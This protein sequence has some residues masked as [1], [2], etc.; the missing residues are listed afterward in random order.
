MRFL[1]PTG[2][3]S[4][5]VMYRLEMTPAFDIKGEGS[6]SVPVNKKSTDNSRL[7]F[8]KKKTDGTQGV[9]GE[10]IFGWYICLFSVMIPKIHKAV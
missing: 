8:K 5:P 9:S 7:L 1:R 10:P 3:I 6:D 2:H 4:L